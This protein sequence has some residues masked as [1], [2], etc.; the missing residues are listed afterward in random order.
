M[1]VEEKEKQMEA[2]KTS[3]FNQFMAHA[4][5]R[6]GMAM[7]PAPDPEQ[8]EVLQ[9]LLKAAFDA[10]WNGGAGHIALDVVKIMMTKKDR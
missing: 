10:G 3:A 7:I 4:M 6:M 2:A 8:K 5:T 1:N 9:H